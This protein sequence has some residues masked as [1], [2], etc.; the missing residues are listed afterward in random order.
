MPAHSW[1]W[2]KVD[3]MVRMVSVMVMLVTIEAAI[4]IHCAVIV[5]WLLV[6]VRLGMCWLVVAGLVESLRIPPVAFRLL[7]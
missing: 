4:G 2:L 1:R 7:Q 6:V 5:A 3:W